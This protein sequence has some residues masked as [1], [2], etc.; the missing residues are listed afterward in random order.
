MS[1]SDSRILDS[2]S[3]EKKNKKSDL[4]VS[5]RYFKYGGIGVVIGHEITHA[6]D[7]A[8]EDLF[9]IERQTFKC[10]VTRNV[11]SSHV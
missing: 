10:Y 6:F 8:G 9:T 3:L 5:L 11:I 7:S 1:Q 2:G 4:L